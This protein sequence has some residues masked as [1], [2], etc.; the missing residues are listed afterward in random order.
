MALLFVMLWS[1]IN[2]LGINRVDVTLSDAQA[3]DVVKYRAERSEA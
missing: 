1:L 2:Q 3:D